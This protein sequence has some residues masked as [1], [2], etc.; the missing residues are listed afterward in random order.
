[1]A[2]Q[3]YFFNAVQNGGVYD[4]V[5]NAED[6]T[7]YLDLL[8]GNG[9]FPTPSTQLQVRASSGMDVIVGAG[10]GWINGHKMINTADLTLTLTASDVLLNRI[11][12]VVFY[13][14][15]NT[16]QMGIAVKTGTVAA[17]PSAPAL[18]Q[19][20]NRFELCLAQISVP[21]QATEITASMITDTRG[22]SSLCGYV[23]GLI[24]QLDSTTL[25]Q[26]WQAQ[27]DEWF[28]AAKEQFQAGK[29]FKK[30]EGIHVTSQANESSFKVTK[31]V[32]HYSFVYDILEVYV[33]G[34]HLNGNEYT[35][36]NSTVTLE[37]PIEDAG[38]VVTFVVY[39]S[40]DN[41]Q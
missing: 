33:N 1:M 2:I 27:F 16:R 24:Q 15:H 40:V 12:A 35:I 13:A 21:K 5:Y 14:D 17:T 4:R 9:V 19:D 25:F 30:L 28:N 6:F 18:Q 26:Q 36:T 11:D 29:V 32:P 37:T 23:Q 31:Y 10:S 20:D 8:V 3:S 39:Q 22:D 7:S 38:A 41:E 34:I